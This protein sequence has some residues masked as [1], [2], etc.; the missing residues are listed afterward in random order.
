MGETQNLQSLGF[1]TV[2]KVKLLCEAYCY[3]RF[4]FFYEGTTRYGFAE[5]LQA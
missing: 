1:E 2:R 3:F 5:P 4:A